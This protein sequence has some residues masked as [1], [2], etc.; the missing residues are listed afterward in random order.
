MLLIVFLAVAEPPNLFGLGGNPIRQFIYDFQT[1]F[2]G[3]L[4]IA[5][6]Y[7]T[8]WQMRETDTQAEGRHAQ[9]VSLTIRKDALRV[10]RA[11]NPDVDELNEALENMRD[12]VRAL[13]NPE[14]GKILLREELDFLFSGVEYARERINRGDVRETEE[15]FDGEMIER[16]RK[17]R[18][19]IDDALDHKR[20]ILRYNSITKGQQFPYGTGFYDS[21][22][23][24]VRE[25]LE[26]IVDDVENF[27]SRLE[28]LAQEY[29]TLMIVPTS[30]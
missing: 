21:Y 24:E 25:S 3:I 30:N 6:A 10:D 12:A 29:R 22:V 17:A 9:Q 1:L 7:F 15:L 16:L 19:R 27:R 18:G 23:K 4:A 11:A 20:E 8:V 2:G 13:R 14:K 28:R 5:A 26:R